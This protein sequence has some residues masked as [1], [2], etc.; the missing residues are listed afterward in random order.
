MR[1][2]LMALLV[3]SSACGRVWDVDSYRSKT[4]AA[5]VAG[6]PVEIVVELT[7]DFRAG[8]DFTSV[9]VRTDEGAWDLAVF[10]GT[11]FIGMRVAGFPGREGVDYDVEVELALGGDAVATRR[12]RGPTTAPQTRVMATIA[13]DC[14]AE[15]PPDRD[16]PATE[17]WGDRCVPPECPALP[18][19]CGD[20]QCTDETDCP[21]SD[22]ALRLCTGECLELAVEDACDPGEECVP[23]VGCSGEMDAG[24]RDAGVDGGI[25]AGMSCVETSTRPCGTVGV[26]AGEETCVGGEWTGCTAGTAR[27]YDVCLD[28]L[29]NDCDGNVD[30]PCCTETSSG[31]LLCYPAA[32][33]GTW[34]LRCEAYG[35]RLASIDSGEENESLLRELDERA[36]IGLTDLTEEG[37]FRWRLAP[38]TGYRNFAVEPDDP[39]HLRNC[40]AMDETGLWRDFACSLP[41]PAICER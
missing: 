30:A 17:C 9:N 23:G 40:V 36:W 3:S 12:F 33:W 4:D 39:D 5:D 18:D 25:D 13:R 1:S 15:C 8:L 26:C 19:A 37:V 11:T 6:D 16:D 10:E 22:C 28:G 31:H 14:A 7:T 41:F 27:E 2:L 29:D 38:D 21:S 24:M 20:L 32:G 34:A 35:Y